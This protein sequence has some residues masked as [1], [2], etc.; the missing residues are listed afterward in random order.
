MSRREIPTPISEWRR[1]TPADPLEA[2]DWPKGTLRE[3][4]FTRRPETALQALLETAPG[5][6]P[7]IS[8]EEL[9]G[10]QTAVIDAIERLEPRLRFVVDAINSERLSLAQLGRRMGI[11]K[12]HAHRLREQAFAALRAEL[13]H[14]IHVRRRLNMTPENWQDA[15][16]DALWVLAPSG[17]HTDVDLNTRIATAMT[18]LR[19]RFHF[20]G[21]DLSLY[22]APAIKIGRAAAGWL[23]NRGCWDIDSMHALL[24]RKQADYGHGNINAFGAKGVIV[25][26]SDKVER[27]HNLTLNGTVP[28][29]ESMIDTY[30]DIVGYATIMLMLVNNTFNLEY[31]N[32]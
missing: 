27:M 14:N 8:V 18:D 15:A 21:D 31:T 11:S 28:F 9:E 30:D 16:F 26:L 23:A 17:D 32:D 10:I 13:E 12:T 4:T 7:E 1:H 5:E 25:R 22:Q 20:D 2:K 6:T 3:T 19:T 29:N 24:C